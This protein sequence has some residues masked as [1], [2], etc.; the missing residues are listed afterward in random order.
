MHEKRVCIPPLHTP[1]L[2]CNTCVSFLTTIVFCV[3]MCIV[4][5][6]MESIGSISFAHL[7]SGLTPWDWAS[8]AGAHPGSESPFLRCN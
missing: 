8:C 3:Y 7:Y 2:F 1:I 4:Y 6:N 5:M